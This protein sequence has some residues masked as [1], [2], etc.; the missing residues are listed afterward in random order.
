MAGKPVV[1]SSKNND[2]TSQTA[3]TLWVGSSTQD[4]DA[5][6]TG[7]V[8]NIKVIA[9]ITIPTNGTL[10]GSIG[11]G[12]APGA[13][14]AHINGPSESYNTVLANGAYVKTAD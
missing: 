5:S 13:T 6:V 4:T 9:G 3:L 8:P 14:N 7:T 2:V 11:G 12:N 1:D 10:R